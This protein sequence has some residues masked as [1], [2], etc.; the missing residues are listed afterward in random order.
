MSL[1]AAHDRLK[2]ALAKVT[3]D[4]GMVDLLPRYI[5][6]VSMAQEADEGDDAKCGAR[7]G[8]RWTVPQ[9]FFACSLLSFIFSCGSALGLA[10]GYSLV[11]KGQ[12]HCPGVVPPNQA[13]RRLAT[14]D[15]PSEGGEYFVE[16]CFDKMIQ[17]Y[18]DHH[19]FEEITGV[20]GHIAPTMHGQVRE[21]TIWS[22]WYDPVDCP[23]SESCTLPAAIELCATS[24]RKNRGEFDFHIL[25]MDTVRNF[26]NTMELPLQW[27]LLHPVQQKEVLMNAL[28]ARYGGVA[29]DLTTVLLRPLDELWG[30]L[31]L[32]QATFRGYMYRVNGN[33]WEEPEATATWFMMS[34][35]EGIFSTAVRNQVVKYCDAY[36]HP[37]AALGD[38]TV[39]PVLGSINTSLPSCFDDDSVLSKDGCPEPLQPWP[40]Q[41]AV[42]HLDPPRTDRRLLIT[43]PRDGPFLPF[44][45]LDNFGMGTWRV[46]DTSHR[47][48]L[49][50]QC[51]SPSE[52]WQ[53]VVLPRYN[54][55]SLMFV[56]LFKH[57]GALARR[58]RK[59]LLGDNSTYFHGWLKL[60]GVDAVSHH[61]ADPADDD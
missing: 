3:S 16:P 9:L 34:R 21:K 49:P 5:P 28:L 50:P 15:A 27:Q 29:L 24:I 23:T 17:L 32:H 4:P 36:N 48:G 10:W 59:D 47:S 6:V 35:R 44:S 12:H 39:T 46:N 18:G 56:K 30:D 25:H 61:L 53:K 14:L 55:G 26:V 8:Q 60:A 41:Q 33:P 54:V 58:S 13:G 37:D 43:D 51:G 7:S 2:G 1:Q 38:W 11:T 45:R 40:N 57:G 52:C 22:Y 19:T 42:P 31:V 20:K